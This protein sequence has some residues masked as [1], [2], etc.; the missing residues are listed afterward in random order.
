MLR[1]SDEIILHR[2]SNPRLTARISGRLAKLAMRFLTGSKGV[3]FA[4][5]ILGFG[6]LAVT[7]YGLPALHFSYDYQSGFSGERYKTWCR[8]ISM[9]GMYQR[10]ASG[11]RCSWIVLAPR[12]EN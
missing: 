6:Y 12:E 9:D 2:K 1:Q 4:S 7:K 5:A 3:L 8:Y 11:G 10:A